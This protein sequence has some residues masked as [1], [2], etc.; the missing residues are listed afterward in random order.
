[1]F[2]LILSLLERAGMNSSAARAILLISSL[3]IIAYVVWKAKGFMDNNESEHRLIIARLEALAE[4]ADRTDAKV[5]RV[6][7]KVD[8]I[9][10]RLD[11]VE[12]KV[13][14]IDTSLNR[15]EVKVDEIDVSL[16]RVE[17]KVDRIETRMGAIDVKTDRLEEKKDGDEARM[18]RHE[19]RM[20][21]LEDKLN[22]LTALVAKIAGKVD[23]LADTMNLVLFHITG[24]MDVKL[25]QSKSPLGL[26]PLGEELRQKFG[27]DKIIEKYKQ[28]L[29]SVFEDELNRA[30]NPYD[31]QAITFDAVNLKLYDLLNEEELLLLKNE[32]FRQSVATEYF[33]T[34]FRILFRDEILKDKGISIDEF[35]SKTQQT[36]GH[37]S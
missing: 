23:I 21:T 15:V 32:A 18:N 25:A 4:R 3:T 28:A 1:M 9:D 13:D 22:N 12:V 2:D 20:D 31:I 17:M 30:N 10:V 36:D 29:C 11:K 16:N 35:Y 14:E 5:D 19:H 33:K 37:I 27:A 8:G 34:I 24:K 6:E 7:V 26:S